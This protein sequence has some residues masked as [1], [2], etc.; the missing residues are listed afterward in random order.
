[1]ILIQDCYIS[2]YIFSD[3]Q[4]LEEKVKIIDINDIIDYLIVKDENE[5]ILVVIF[6]QFVTYDNFKKMRKIDYKNI[7]IIMIGT[8]EQIEQVLIDNLKIKKANIN[9]IISPIKIEYLKNIL[10]TEIFKCLV[11]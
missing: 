5:K 1:M 8:K 2:Q 10:K 7:D 9:K 6:S 11:D 3:I 4:F